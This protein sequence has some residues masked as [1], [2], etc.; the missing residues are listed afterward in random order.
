MKLSITRKKTT[1]NR[2]LENQKQSK[3]KYERLSNQRIVVI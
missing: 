1:L 3:W 2:L